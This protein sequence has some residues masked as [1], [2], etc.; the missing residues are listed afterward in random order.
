MGSPPAGK[1]FCLKVIQRWLAFPLRSVRFYPCCRSNWTN[2]CM[3]TQLL[4]RRKDL[5]TVLLNK[6]PPTWLRQ[7]ARIA[8][9]LQGL[10][11][12][13]GSLCFMLRFLFY[14]EFTWARQRLHTGEQDLVPMVR[15]P[16]VAV[17]VGLSQKALSFLGSSHSILL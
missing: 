10:C 8:V 5:S 17:T 4:T 1:D 2:H 6:T 12:P 7:A 11:A 13:P 9:L 16:Q 15:G 14:S 3:F